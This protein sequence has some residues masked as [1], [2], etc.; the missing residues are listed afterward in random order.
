[1]ADNNE[2]FE[3]SIINEDKDSDTLV[4]TSCS[5]ISEKWLVSAL[6]DYD[7]SNQTY[8]AYL[9]DG[10]SPSQKITPEYLDELAE[11]AQNDINKI[12]T[13][14]SIIRKQINKNDI[15]GKTV[16][17]IDTNINTQIKL[18]YNA[19]VKDNQLPL[20]EVKNCI[21]DFNNMIHIKKLTRNSISTAFAEGN[22]FMYLRHNNNCYKVDYYPIGVVEVAEWDKDGEPILL[23]NVQELRSRLQK[24]YKK[25]RKNKYLFFDSMEAEVKNNY[26]EEVYNAFVAKEKYAKLDTRY[27]GVIR[28]NNLNRRYGVS[29]IF[30]SLDSLSMLDTFN[31]SDRVNSKAKAKKIIHQ[32]L[33]KEVMGQEFNKQGFEEMA[34]AHQ[35]FMA[36]WKQPTVVVTTPPTVE[37]IN[38]VEPKIE[39]TDINSINNYR[40]RVLSTLGIG[41]LMDS[42][43]QSVSTASISVTQLMR[44]INT[45]SEQLEEVLKKWYCQILLDS[46]LDVSLCPDI[47][48][49]DSEALDFSLRKELA[50]TL[51]TI[52]NGSLETSLNILGVDIND[53]TAKRIRENDVNL[54][55]EVFY[56]RCTSYT[57]SGKKTNFDEGKSKSGRP[58]SKTKTNKTEYDDTYNQNAR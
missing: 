26:P 45:I 50:T 43:S 5:D 46:G 53:E 57:S 56:P 17:C 15:V 25:T 41:F 58:K 42:S 51:Y 48:I 21:V 49:I 2:D 12:Q 31:N 23:F 13:I 38:Y 39:L 10:N 27:S 18:S 8:S 37:S 16:E 7:P 24:V 29:P 11:N 19:E 32:K 4:V 1:M 52:F 54:D 47:E 36:A 3:V 30:R 35:N 6:N 44:T 28:I 22:Y 14:N 34:Y 20:N 40:S 33:R 55:T 9:K